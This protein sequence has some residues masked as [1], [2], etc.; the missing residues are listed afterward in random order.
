LVVLGVVAALV[1]GGGATAFFVVGAAGGSVSG[2]TEWYSTA[3]LVDANGDDVLDVAGRMGRPGSDAHRILVLDG[4][5]GT[6]LW[7][8][9]PRYGFESWVMCLSSSTI[10]VAQRDFTVE[11]YAADGGAPDSDRLT[12]VVTQYGASDDCAQL[13]LA[14]GTSVHFDLPSR[15]RGDCLAELSHDVYG[16]PLS[17]TFDYTR[18]VERGGTFYTAA[19]KERGTPTLT[20]SAR[21]DDETLWEIDLG[22]MPIQRQTLLTVADDTVLTYAVTPADSDHGV[23]VG[24]DR[25]TGATK[26]E[27]RIANRFSTSISSELSFNGRHAILVVAFGVRAFDPSTGELVWN[28][29]NRR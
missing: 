28:L 9:E 3:C 27:N 29:G 25:E 2:L 21:R 11:L 14:D 12:D 16:D 23:L 5:E 19:P 20:V 4:I 26:F 13:K 10:G 1:A 24:L 6:K 17:P 22:Y 8:S 7:E 18:R 15:T